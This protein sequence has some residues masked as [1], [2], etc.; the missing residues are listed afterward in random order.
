MF[1]AIKEGGGI[2]VF[3][4]DTEGVNFKQGLTNAGFKFAQSLVW[5]KNAITLGRQD[6]QWRHESVIYGW[7]EGAAH[8]FIPRRD[9]DTVYDEGMPDI[10]GMKVKELRDLS[11]EELEKKLSDLKDELFSL[12]FQSVTGQLS[13]YMKIKDVKHDI[14]RAKTILTEN[15]LKNKKVAESGNES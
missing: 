5:V 14:A 9:Q 13:N 1:K 6:Y 2:Y 12:R 3:H 8:Y 11:N 10:K 15:Y 4:A 7:K